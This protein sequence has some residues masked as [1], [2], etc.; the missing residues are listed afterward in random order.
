MSLRTA[1][2]DQIAEVIE[3]D[4]TCRNVGL[5]ANIATTSIPIG[6]TIIRTSGYTVAGKGGGLWITDALATPGLMALYPLLV[7]QSADGRYFRA[8]APSGVLMADQAGALNDNATVNT[9]AIQAALDYAKATEIPTV[10]FEGGT[11]RTRQITMPV[12]TTLQGQGSYANTTLVRDPSWTGTNNT[13]LQIGSTAEN[14]FGVTVERLAFDLN[15]AGDYGR[16]IQLGQQDIGGTLRTASNIRI[17]DCRFRDSAPVHTGGD[18]WA[19]LFRANLQNV[20]IERCHSSGD[21]QFCAGGTDFYRNVHILNN[22]VES[23]FANGIAMSTGRSNH[24]V[25]GLFIIGNYIEATALCVFLGPDAIYVGLTG[26]KWRNVQVKDNHC[27][28]RGD[29][30]SQTGWM[31]VY[32]NATQSTYKRVAVTGNIIEN[33]D[34]LSNQVGI[35]FDDSIAYGTHVD[36]ISANDNVISLCRWGIEAI[37]IGRGAI[38]DNTITDCTDGILIR[39]ALFKCGI[40]GNTITGGSRAISVIKG[41]VLVTGNTCPGGTGQTGTFTGR[42]WL[43]PGAGQTARVV[44]N[45][46]SFTDGAAGPGS[47]YGV[48]KA[49]A[50][51]AELH[52][53]GN[54]LTGNDAALDSITPNSAAK[55][56]GYK[57][58]AHGSTGS[59][60]T[61]VD[62]AHGLAATPNLVTLTPTATGPSA[63][64]VSD[65][66]ATTFRVN[67]SGAG[68]YTFMWEAKMAIDQ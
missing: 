30:T 66:G 62:V 7:K 35:R 10:S 45:G 14:V 3:R 51:T 28:T 40:A 39:E 50:G 43:E 16:C 36:E 61:G 55:N 53:I 42:L 20:W 63:I 9:A 65:I 11:Y 48:R 27:T 15:G 68:P 60:A 64:F 54:D 46:N 47:N 18:K 8:Y 32:L 19:I 2:L 17:L 44:A 49:G 4:E 1:R 22:R 57:T 12:S 67:Y 31:G 26:G 24:E 33:R 52:L 29:G 37:R 58:S 34:T 21:Q 56:Q 6:A 41:D 5:V 25:D 38:N 23:G 13:I 59:I